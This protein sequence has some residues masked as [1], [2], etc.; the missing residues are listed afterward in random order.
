MN[1]TIPNA[2]FNEQGEISADIGGIAVSVHAQSCTEDSPGIMLCNRSPIVEVAFPGTKSIALEPE[3]LYLD[4]NS[5]FY[6]GSLDENYKKN[7][8]S[9]ILTDINGDGHEDVVLWSGKEGNYG[10]P[11]YSVYIFDPVQQ[12]LVFNQSLSDITVMANGLFSVKGSLLTSTSGDGCCIHV[13]DTYE[14][15]KNEPVLTERVTEDTN[16][17]ANPKK[18]IERLQDGKMKEVSN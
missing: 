13:F 4:S 8:H 7:R 14:L 3:A 12:R 1:Q 15:K 9:I 17:P 10:G 5:T 2:K 16:D 6:H 11:S 18:K